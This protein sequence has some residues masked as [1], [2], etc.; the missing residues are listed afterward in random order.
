M[1]TF[2]P[3]VFTAAVF[4]L[5]ALASLAKAGVPEQAQA[6]NLA[7]PEQKE[8]PYAGAV[9]VM[10]CK[11]VNAIVMIDHNGTVHPVRLKDGTLATLLTQLSQAPADKVVQVEMPC[12]EEKST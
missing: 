8:L 4:L 1:K 3:L 10:S 11:L 12:P 2:R 6:S 9:V 7:V 5:I